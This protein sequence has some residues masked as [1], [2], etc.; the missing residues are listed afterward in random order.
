MRIFKVRGYKLYILLFSNLVYNLDMRYLGNLENF[1]LGMGLIVK[2]GDSIP[3]KNF[4]LEG[5]SGF[6][7]TSSSKNYIFIG[8]GVLILLFLLK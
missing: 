3:A 1:H 4:S 2:P 8:I 5:Y 6:S 7:Q